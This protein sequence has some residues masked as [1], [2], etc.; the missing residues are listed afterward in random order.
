MVFN[1]TRVMKARLYGVRDTG[2]RVE[3]MVERVLDAHMRR[4]LSV[5]V[6]HQ[7]RAPGCS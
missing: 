7:S 5:R 6:T 1:D 2:G 3:V 4:R